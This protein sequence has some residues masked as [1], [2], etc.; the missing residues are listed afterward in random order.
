MSKHGSISCRGSITVGRTVRGTA[1]NRGQSLTDP[2]IRD[3]HQTVWL[4]LLP[5]STKKHSILVHSHLSQAAIHFAFSS[6]N[7]HTANFTSLSQ[8]CC[9]ACRSLSIYKTVKIGQ[10]ILQHRPSH[11]LHGLKNAVKKK[12]VRL[13]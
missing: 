10:C 13:K 4:L 3:S 6:R 12:K 9:A 1:D 5:R 11:L 7:L 8:S 2:E